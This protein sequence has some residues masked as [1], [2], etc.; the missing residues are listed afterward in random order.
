VNIKVETHCR[1]GVSIAFFDDGN[2]VIF[3]SASGDVVTCSS[4]KVEAWL[5]RGEGELADMLHHLGW[6]SE[7]VQIN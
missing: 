2:A 3:L 7:R 5:E 6:G 1:E 4:D